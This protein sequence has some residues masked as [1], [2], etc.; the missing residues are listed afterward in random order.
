MASHGVARSARRELTAQEKAKEL[1]QIDKYKDL[2]SQVRERYYAKDYS[3][4]AL[5]LTSALLTSNPEY[6]TIW[7]YR[8]QILLSVFTSELASASPPS[9]SSESVPSDVPSLTTAQQEISLLI[10]EDLA[11]LLPLQRYNPKVY[12]LWNHRSW[13]LSQ[14]T[15][16]LP[17]AVAKGFWKEELGLVEKMLGRDERNFHGWGYRREVVRNL[18]EL[19]YRQL[20]EADTARAEPIEGGTPQPGTQHSAPEQE[21][22]WRKQASMAQQEFDYADRMIRSNLSN[23]S[24]WHHRLQQIYRLLEDLPSDHARRKEMFDAELELV[25]EGLWVCTGPKDQSLWFYHMD[26]MSTL[27][28]G[29]A[30]GRKILGDIGDE[31][32]RGYVKRQME[33]VREVGE[34]NEDCKWIYQALL[35]LGQLH[36]KFGGEVDEPEMRGLLDKLEMLDP[37]RKGR[38]TDLRRSLG[39]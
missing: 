34:D 21:T 8:R 20:S 6:Y 22:A 23:F 12:W 37:L 32:R 7:N 15:L 11:F 38:W 5:T 4:P 30:E 33:R 25:S 3:S 18:E 10:R 19:S 31:E 1:K 14:A 29:V 36:S 16:H 17:P 28:P 39:L 24:A 35:D 9:P 26:L 13:L 2:V 27:D